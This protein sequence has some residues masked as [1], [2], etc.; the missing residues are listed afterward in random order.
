[1]T[2][3][4]PQSNPIQMNREWTRI[5]TKTKISSQSQIDPPSCGS[6]ATHSGRKAP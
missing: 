1:M 5:Y 4:E 3:Q 6:L 2:N